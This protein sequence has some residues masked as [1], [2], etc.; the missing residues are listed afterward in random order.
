MPVRH[1]GS[2]PV[3]PAILFPNLSTTYVFDEPFGQTCWDFRGRLDLVNS[4][5]PRAGKKM[6]PLLD[7]VSPE[8]PV[9]FLLDAVK[10]GPEKAYLQRHSDNQAA[11]FLHEWM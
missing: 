11:R 3:V 4:I 1:A 7:V 10:S 2:S 8:H 5:V 6:R 9:V